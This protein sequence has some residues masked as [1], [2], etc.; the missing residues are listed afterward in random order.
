M[1]TTT[2]DTL[3]PNV[4]S[5][6]RSGIRWLATA[7]KENR[8]A[9][10]ADDP[11]LGK[12]VQALCVAEQIKARRILVVSPAGARRVWLTQ[13]KQWFPSWASRIRVLE[14][15]TAEPKPADIAA[16]DTILLVSYDLF[17]DRKN[18]WPSTIK[19]LAWDLLVLDEAHFLKNT[20]NRTQAIY[21]SRGDHEGVQ[22]SASYVL[23][24]TGTPTPNHCGELFQHMRTLWP[25]TLRRVNGLAGLMSEDEF[26]EHVCK[27]TTG[28]FG[29]QVTGSK[30]VPWLRTR[31]EP[32]VIRRR[33]LEVLTELPALVEQDVPLGVSPE[34]VGAGLDDKLRKLERRLYGMTDNTLWEAMHVVDDSL[35]LPTLRRKLGEAKIAATAEWVDERLMCGTQKMLVFGW[36]P[37][38]LQRLQSYLTKYEAVLVTGNTPPSSRATLV[39]RFQR[40]AQCRVFIGQIKAAGTALTLTAASEVT[41][42]EP[43][44]VPG[45]NRQSIDRA[46]RMGQRDSVLATY[47]YLPDTLDER[48]LRVMRRK[49]HDIREFTEKETLSHADP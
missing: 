10:L 43:S 1:H 4:R 42:M 39:D 21:G 14:P 22:S 25:Q 33:K 11:G 7:L 9:L 24:L 16:P 46:H 8:A 12:T 6:Q 20:S 29:R 44:W 35:P 36:H 2:T 47:L 34:V 38:V 27:F 28:Q 3:C 32:F 17:S 40:R 48:I 18:H 5:Y 49:E 19:G 23:L 45:D 41:M 26:I 30:N 31:L 15:G 13:I 37:M